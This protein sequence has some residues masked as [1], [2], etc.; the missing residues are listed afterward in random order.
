MKLACNVNFFHAGMN[1]MSL[2]CNWPLILKHLLYFFALYSI[3]ILK[4]MQKLCWNEKHLSD[5]WH[6]ICKKNL[7]SILTIVSGVT[8][9]FFYRIRFPVVFLRMAALKK[10]KIHFRA[11]NMKSKL[12]VVANLNEYCTFQEIL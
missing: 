5:N 4:V 1:F 3:N 7:I 10:L 9:K 12:T 8:A 2:T 11:T 6:Q